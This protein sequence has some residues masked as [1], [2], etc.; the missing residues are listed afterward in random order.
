[1]KADAVDDWYFNQLH[2]GL[3]SSAADSGLR[4]LFQLS[5]GKD[6]GR[7]AVTYLF[8]RADGTGQNPLKVAESLAA[9]SKGQW[10]PNS[11]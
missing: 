5:V 11:K 7:V 1:M 3:G 2:A 8:N 9:K 6:N 4:Y 10:W